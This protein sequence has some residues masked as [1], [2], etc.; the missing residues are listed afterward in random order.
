MEN[1]KYYPREPK[2]AKGKVS[3]GKA[4]RADRPFVRRKKHAA[5]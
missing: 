2:V 5:K 3:K 1:K 4:K